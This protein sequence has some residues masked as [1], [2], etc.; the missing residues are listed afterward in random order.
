M[1]VI[2]P[3]IETDPTELEQ[4][5][6][7]YLQDALPG[8]EPAEGDLMTWLIAAHARMVAEERDI[9]ADVPL[10]Q[11]LR[12]LGEEVHRVLPRVAT[13][14]TVEATVT[15]RDGLG[16]TIPKGA[17]MLVRTAGDDG[18][19]MAVV[20][21]VTVA[22]TP[23]EPAVKGIAIVRL[24]AIAGRE[25]T[26]GNGLRAPDNTVVPIRQLEFIESVALAG[27][28]FGG[29][30]AESDDQY[31]QRLVDTLALTSPV[32]ILA[33]DFA[34]LAR[35]Q[36]GVG[37]ALALNNTVLNDEIVRIEADART[38]LTL[39]D[40]ATSTAYPIA[41][42]ATN[43][44]IRTTFAAFNPVV[45]G[46]PIGTAA[47]TLRLRD[48]TRY[49]PWRLSLSTTATGT[50]PVTAVG[51]AS[52][53]VLQRGGALAVRER[54]VTVAVIGPDGG[55]VSTDTLLAVRTALESVRELNWE[56][57]VIEPTSVPINVTY[58]AVT[59]PTYDPATVERAAAA[60]LTAYLSPARWGMGD[61]VG[62][63]DDSVWVD[64]R[65]VRYL[66]VAQVLN[67]VP[68]LRYVTSLSLSGA[69]GPD[70][71]GNI[72]L[73]GTVPMPKAGTIRSTVR[74]G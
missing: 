30:D 41:A 6:I 57:S 51:S 14:A 37:R 43:D 67:E 28:S 12:P 59:W 36:A 70:A 17:E 68:G 45:E 15:L 32:P 65:T 73:T 9:A 19:T 63:D 5:A 61:G 16:Y 13:P 11:I 44:A 56:V 10:E 22:P 72:Q 25:G 20:D 18:V 69:G 64:E 55:S 4:I 40:G 3:E 53:A 33:D 21:D 58:S 60:A 35:Q 23:G 31:L 1:A 52:L 38:A 66:E 71:A 42:A 26:A 39:T 50:S 62:G 47:V 34:A 74:E 7:A 29:T 49:G 48:R 46:G 54:S 24:R 8:W 27:T 2:R